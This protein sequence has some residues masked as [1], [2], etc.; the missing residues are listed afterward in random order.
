MDQGVWWTTV[1][2]LAKSQTQLKQLSEHLHTHTH[3]LYVTFCFSFV[4]FNIFFFVFNF[5]AIINICFGVVLLGL[6]LYGTLLSDLVSYFISSPHVKEEFLTMIFSNFLR[7]FLF[8]LLFWD[9]YNLNVD[10]F[11]IVP[12]VFETVLYSLH[13]FFILLLS[14]YFHDPIFPF[15]YLFICLSYSAID[16]F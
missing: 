13:S 4:A 16:F 15:T 6:I 14:S 10:A 8:F 5:G 1:H 9:Q 3:P 11:N 12:E 7:P 2:G